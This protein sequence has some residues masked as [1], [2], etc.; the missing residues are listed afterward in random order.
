MSAAE[1][2]QPRTALALRQAG[3]EFLR[4]PSKGN[5]I[6]GLRAPESLRAVVTEEIARRAEQM[7]RMIPTADAIVPLLVIAARAPNARA[8]Y[9]LSCSEEMEPHLGGQCDLCHAALQKALR[10]S[11]RIP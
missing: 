11:G 10:A 3:V 7:Q 1:K 6:T 8:G 5:R 9:C 4:D 2:L